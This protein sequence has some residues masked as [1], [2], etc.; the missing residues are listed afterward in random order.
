MFPTE[1]L[2]QLVLRLVRVLVLIN[3]QMQELVL[4][5]LADRVGLAKQRDCAQQ[6]IVKVQRR[7]GIELTLVCPVDA[8]DLLV[9]RVRGDARLEV[10]RVEQLVL[11]GTDRMR[12]AARRQAFLVNPLSTYGVANGREA[13]SLVVDRVPR[14][15]PDRLTLT[16][17]QP[18]AQ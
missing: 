10:A 9:H 1:N 18:R 4:V 14:R 2:D 5:I 12:S 3:E 11:R 7:R 13:V 6:Q 15:D 17:Q 16:P 8:R